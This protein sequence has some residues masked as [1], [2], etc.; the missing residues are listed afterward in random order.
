[1]IRV[2]VNPSHLRW[3]RERAGFALEDLAAKFNK[4]S[5]SESGETQPT[6]KQLEAFARTVHA[7]F[8][9]C[10]A[11]NFQRKLCRFRTFGPWPAARSDDRVPICWIR[12]T[13][14]GNGRIGIEM[15]LASQE[16]TISGS[17]GAPRSSRLPTRSRNECGKVGGRSGRPPG[18]FDWN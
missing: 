8:A 10:F 17:S 15:T 12:S 9:I 1:M 11:S 16:R 3:A 4:L 18:M 7:P 14:A 6:L 5:E 2:P 13:F